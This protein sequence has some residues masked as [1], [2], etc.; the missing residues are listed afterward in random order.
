MIWKG[1][2]LNVYLLLSAQ[3]KFTHI[4]NVISDILPCP[5]PQTE[6]T[7]TIFSKIS[8]AYMK[9]V[10]LLKDSLVPSPVS[11]ETPGKCERLDHLMLH[12]KQIKNLFPVWVLVRLN[13]HWHILNCSHVQTENRRETFTCAKS[14][15]FQFVLRFHMLTLKIH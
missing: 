11:L 1:T 7:F 8:Q 5:S 15:Q 10:L 2:Q 6:S 3:I 9:M 14:H 13:G 12:S 4:P